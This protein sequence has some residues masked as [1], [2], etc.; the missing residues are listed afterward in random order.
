MSPEVDER[1]GEILKGAYRF[2]ERI[3]RGAAGAIYR[4]VQLTV[5]R[6]VAIKV[7]RHEGLDRDAL[8]SVVERFRRE[9]M[10]TSRLK[11]PNTVSLLD[12]G[13]TDDGLPFLVLELLEGRPLADVL[14]R[15]GALEPLRAARIG[16]QIAKSL[17]EAHGH[18]IV[19]RDLKPDNVFLCTFDGDADFVKVLDFGIARV[20]GGEDA[21]RHLTADNAAVGTP[22]YMS[23]EQADAQPVG[24]PS[25]IYSLGVVLYELV[26]GRP[27]FMADTFFEIAVK[28]LRHDPEP[29]EL[30]DTDP[31]LEAVWN[32]LLSRL[33]AK[34]PAA[35]PTAGEVIGCLEHL[36]ARHTGL[37]APPLPA[38]PPLPPPP[39]PRPTG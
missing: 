37:A 26:R 25:D 22:V 19:H 20:T 28:H 38:L 35:R 27:P 15:G 5:D 2:E 30:E 34:D 8:A 17:S 12:F 36:I 1:L 21:L 39:P 7:L 23:P 11:H 9:A 29:V 6:P 4:G 13:T 14:R 33:L 24:L 31:A 3:G 10:A 32:D 18:G 16:M